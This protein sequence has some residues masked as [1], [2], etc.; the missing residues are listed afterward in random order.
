MKG[1]TVRK[2]SLTDLPT[3]LRLLDCA[4]K[5][6]RDSGNPH[7]WG[8]DRPSLDQIRKDMEAGNS[9]L[10]LEGD[11]PIG[12]FAF[13]SGPDIT[14]ATIYQGAWENETLPYAVIHRVAGSSQHHR[15]MADILDFCFSVA[16]TIRIDTHRDN[17]LMQHCLDKAGFHYCG[18]IHLLNGDERLAYQKVIER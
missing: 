17:K 9:Y 10:L 15:V 12:T 3:V 8:D 11:T 7:Q 2:A 4:R 5:V 6:M 16:D 13:I 14:Y 1:R 18:I